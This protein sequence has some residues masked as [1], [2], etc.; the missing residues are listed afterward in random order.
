[1]AIVLKNIMPEGTT[2]FIVSG[3]VFMISYFIVGAPVLKSALRNLKKGQWMDEQFLMAIATVGAI[4]TGE[5]QEGS[6]RNA[7]L[8]QIG[9]LFQAIAVE[10]SRQSISELMAIRA[11]EAN[12][13]VNGNIKKVPVE[14]VYVD[15]IIVIRPGEKYLLTALF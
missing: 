11:D 3:I 1:M 6:F 7:F 14:D 4:G 15:D 2:N 9:E 10:N 13:K 5:F 8:Y 12:I